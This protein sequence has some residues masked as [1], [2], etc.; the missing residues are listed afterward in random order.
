MSCINSRFCPRK[1]Q[2]QCDPER[3]WDYVPPLPD[4]GAV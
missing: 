2:S 4:E 1:A 3:C